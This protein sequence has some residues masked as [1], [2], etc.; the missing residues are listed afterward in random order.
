MKRIILISTLLCFSISHSQKRKIRP[1]LWTHHSDNTDIYGVSVGLYPSDLEYQ[2]TYSRTFGVRIAASPISLLHIFGGK[3]SQG[4]STHKTY[5]INFSTGSLIKMDIH[6]VS[7]T[8]IT[9]N[10]KKMNGISASILSNQIENANGI[11]AAFGGNGVVQ[12]NGIMIGGPWSNT[13]KD[14]N[15]IQISFQNDI[16]EYGT[17]I[18]IGLFN[19]AK[20]F[21][22]IQIGL[23]N[24]INGKGFPFIN[25]D[26]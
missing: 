26:F 12:G 20:R 22:G 6:G 25:W 7:G 1:L 10:L 17:G 4:N 21:N 18:Q 13:A 11:I 19:N 14:F 15:G 2:T 24:K 5:G 8:V 23:W 9:N 16:I 3:P